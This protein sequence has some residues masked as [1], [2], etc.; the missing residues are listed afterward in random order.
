MVFDEFAAGTFGPD[1]GFESREW[2]LKFL[3][4]HTKGSAA[5][6]AASS[7]GQDCFCLFAGTGSGKTKAAG[8]LASHLLNLKLINQI[9]FVCPSDCIA[10]KTIDDFRHFFR[11]NMGD[12]AIGNKKGGLGRQYQGYAVNYQTVFKRWEHHRSNC[13]NDNTLVI[14]DE[15][16][17]L[18]ETASWG[19]TCKK[20]FGT[21]PYVLALTGTPYRSDDTSIPFI[22]YAKTAGSTLYTLKA[23]YSYTLGRAVA[24][25]V[26]RK[27]VFKTFDVSVSL[28]NGHDSGFR[29][30]TFDDTNISEPDA[31]DRL[32]FAVAPG[33]PGRERI[34]RAALPKCKEAGRKVV[35]FLGGDADG[36]NTP[37]TDAK[38]DLPELLQKLG[39]TEDDY[40]VITHDD[41]E[42][43]GKIKEFGK[44]DKWILISVKMVS[45]GI[46][47]PELSAAIFLT[48]IT[49]KQTTIQ[50][51]GRILRMRH[52]DDPIKEG[53]VFIF[54][55]PR[56]AEMCLEAEGEITQEIAIKQDRT[57]EVEGDSGEAGASDRF[58]RTEGVCH[59]D[60]T[61]KSTICH[62]REIPEEEFEKLMDECRKDGLPPYAINPFILV[63][64]R[65]RAGRVDSI[66]SLEPTN[67]HAVTG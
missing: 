41:K 59:D 62:G 65:E 67:G 20:A 4:A 52:P 40:E 24:D 39:Y 31:A 44:S 11:I 54:R 53:W 2:Q 13:G 1:N 18:G 36:K 19:D 32:R 21:A 64:R 47:I 17:H 37:T 16:H 8:L 10:S 38:E 23:D 43:A 5:R 50:R 45:E 42:A 12:Q 49:A 34:L 35:I 48:T 27:P 58:R 63:A 3:R 7:I 15:V 56:Y 30:F 55:D 26:C 66:I 9:V 25:G 60:F 6:K 29:T 46:D 14:F 33:S 51:F 57:P 28:R 61:S 22:R